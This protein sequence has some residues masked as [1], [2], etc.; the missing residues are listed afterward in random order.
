MQLLPLIQYLDHQASA[1]RRA[2][3]EEHLAAFDCPYVRQPYATGTN[4]VAELGP[5][6][7]EVFRHA[8]GIGVD[9]RLRQRA[10]GLGRLLLVLDMLGALVLVHA[11]NG[12]FVADGGY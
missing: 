8:V 4:L 5:H 1:T 11:P 12:V 7:P 9:G 6:G 3:V 10:V 2:I